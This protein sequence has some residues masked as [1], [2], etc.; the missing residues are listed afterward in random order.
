[1]N[2]WPPDMISRKLQCG[3]ILCPHV[4]TKCPIS[5]LLTTTVLH[6]LNQVSN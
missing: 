6:M 1:M 4:H 3:P 5:L 2:S